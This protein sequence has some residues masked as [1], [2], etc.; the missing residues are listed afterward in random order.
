M[1]TWL[2]K[3]LCDSAT[4]LLQSSQSCAVLQRRRATFQP[5][6]DQL[7]TC[8]APSAEAAGNLN[9]YRPISNLSFISKI[10]DRHRA[11]HSFNLLSPVQSIY[12]KHYSTETALVKV[13]VTL[14]R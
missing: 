11:R 13:R 1:P 4:S 12:R 9:S 6:I 3:Q 10:L 8:N 5:I 14:K 7:Y 2:V